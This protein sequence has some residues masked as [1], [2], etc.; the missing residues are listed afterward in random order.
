MLEVYTAQYR[1][2]GPDRYDITVKSGEQAF[3]PTWEMV[4]GYKKGTVSEDAYTGAYQ[5]K[6]GLSYIVKSTKPKWD[7]LL[8]RDRVVLV[9]F[10]KAGDFCHRVLLAKMLVELGAIYKGELTNF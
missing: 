4:L 9:C 6:M 5:A 10:C 2:S 1:Y 3:A 8:K 7:A